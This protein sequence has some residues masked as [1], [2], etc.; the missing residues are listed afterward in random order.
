[1]TEAGA[2]R[3]PDLV[4]YAGYGSNLCAERFRCYL[5]GGIPPGLTRPNRGARD[6]APPRADRPLDLR[7]RLYFAGHAERWGGAPCFVD[8]VESPDSTTRARAYLITWGQFEDVVAQ[9]NGRSTAALDLDPMDHAPGSGISLGPGRYEHLL[10]LGTIGAS[11]V[12]TVTSPQPMTAARLGAPSPAYLNV[13]IAG[14]R[15]SHAMRDDAIIAY[16]GSVRGCSEERV[17]SA[18]AALSQSEG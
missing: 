5:E 13:M 4:W 6:P 14:L 11:P 10:C 7:H 1:M 9:E 12:V 8:T 3:A 16:L 18:L 17:V 15:Q 2:H